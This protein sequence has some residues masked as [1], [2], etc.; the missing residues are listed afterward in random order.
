MEGLDEVK[1]WKHSA[2]GAHMGYLWGSRSSRAVERPPLP[3][4]NQSIASLGYIWVTY[5]HTF[6]VDSSG[7]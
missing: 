1:A 2:S 6:Y 7:A 4:A 3:M 5:L